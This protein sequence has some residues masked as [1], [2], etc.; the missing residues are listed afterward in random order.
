VAAAAAAGV[1]ARN[2]EKEEKDAEGRVT[3]ARGREI[4][5]PRE[6]QIEINN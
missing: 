2:R 6:R 3:D 4:I 5:S 1:G